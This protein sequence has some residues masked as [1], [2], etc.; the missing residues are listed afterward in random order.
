MKNLFIIPLLILVTFILGCTQLVQEENKPIPLNQEVLSEFISSLN[1][2]V[3]D[4]STTYMRENEV[5]LWGGH[6]G[7]TDYTEES[8][9]SIEVKNGIITNY[10]KQYLKVGWP[11]K[12]EDYFESLD[13]SNQLCRNE[14]TE[15]VIGCPDPNN[16]DVEIV[17][18]LTC[19]NKLP[20]DYD[21]LIKNEILNYLESVEITSISKD[22]NEDGTC[23]TIQNSRS[24]HTFCFGDK[25]LIIFA[26][27]GNNLVESDRTDVEIN[28][29][30]TRPN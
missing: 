14:K 30:E 17:E 27:W 7:A 25:N 4:Y 13:E 15:V 24:T 28:E 18:T 11:V 12:T 21:S 16:C 9:V 19:G 23:Y 6:S 8:E 2:K 10:T 20:E 3:L 22:I 26:K 5:H 1:T 29:V